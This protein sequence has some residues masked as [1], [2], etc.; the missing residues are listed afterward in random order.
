MTRIGRMFDGLKRDGRKGLI[1]YLT[2]ATRRRTAPPRLV[3]ALER[4]GADLIELGV[5]FSDPIADGPSSSGPASARSKPAP[6]LRPCSP[7]PPGFASVPKS[8]CCSSPTSTR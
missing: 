3:E 7:S 5:P 6:R 8:R 2:P 4:G 1:A